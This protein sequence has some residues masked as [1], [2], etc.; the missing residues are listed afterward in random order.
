MLPYCKFYIVFYSIIKNLYQ[1][2]IFNPHSILV[3][4]NLTYVSMQ[5]HNSQILKTFFINFIFNLVQYKICS[6]SKW[7]DNIQYLQVKLDKGTRF[8]MKS[9][10][11]LGRF[12]RINLNLPVSQ[13]VVSLLY[14]IMGFC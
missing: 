4:A 2:K 5:L 12:C 1:N 10:G 14:I 7:F 9:E 6:N 11:H 8:S 3:F 13:P